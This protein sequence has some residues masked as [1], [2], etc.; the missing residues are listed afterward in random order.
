MRT[1]VST[2]FLNLVS[3]YLGCMLTWI[4]ETDQILHPFLSTIRWTKEPW[5]IT[6]IW[7]EYVYYN[8]I[9]HGKYEEI[10]RSWLISSCTHT[11]QMFKNN[12]SF[13][14]KAYFS[15]CRCNYD[16][17]V[18]AILSTTD[19]CGES[20]WKN[21]SAPLPSSAFNHHWSEHFLNIDIRT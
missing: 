1:T 12:T 21:L 9:I 14:R 16:T 8:F 10:W 3:K 17:P 11:S 20:C 19:I 18:S 13:Q 7:N 5:I 2:L 6:W 15:F 4:D